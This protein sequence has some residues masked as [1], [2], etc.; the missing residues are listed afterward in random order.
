MQSALHATFDSRDVL[1]KLNMTEKFEK[2]IDEIADMIMQI[3]YLKTDITYLSDKSQP[4][5]SEV[6]ENSRFLHRTYWNSIKL[7]IIDLN[8][9]INPEED[10]SF[11]KA[12]NFVLSN[13]KNI[14]WENEITLDQIIDLQNKIINIEKNYLEKIKNL[15]NKVYAHND[16][17]K[18]HLNLPISLQECWEINEELQMVF[19]RLHW[20]LRKQMFPI[21]EY[22]PKPEEIIRLQKYREIKTYVFK[23]RA[24][25][26][27]STDIENIQKIILSKKPA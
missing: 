6:V 25:N 9:L 27:V 24:E 12:L 5:F 23:S 8:K 1:R 15:R 14:D 20:H 7:L 11:Q 13:R 2:I 17:K 19:N 3:Q 26:N 22:A 18:E 16:R 4:Y 21:S 10:F